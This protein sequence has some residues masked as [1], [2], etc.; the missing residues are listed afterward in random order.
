MLVITAPG[1]DGAAGANTITSPGTGK[2]VLTVGASGNGQS[3]VSNH[4]AQGTAANAVAG[5]SSR[6]PAPFNR[7]KPDIV[8][9]G[10]QIA[11]IKAQG[12]AANANKDHNAHNAYSYG[13]GTSYAAPYV[14]GMAALVRQFLSNNAFHNNNNAIG[15]R[16][17]PSGMLV[18][19]FIINGAHRINPAG[20][21][22]PNNNEGYG[23][24]NLDQ[25]I[26]PARLKL[27]YD[28]GDA[29]DQHN[30]GNA[31]S[32]KRQNDTEKTFNLNLTNQPLSITLVWYDIIDGGV[33]GALVCDLDLT[34]EAANGDIYR[35]DVM[36]L[37]TVKAVCSI[38]D[39]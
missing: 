31:F 13:K 29:Q 11:A 17:T 28:S 39:V 35:G 21:H 16:A 18:K 1:N 15:Q 5:L 34:L 38:P 2:N 9:P 36:V 37:I 30:N 14:S 8:A 12:I 19:A 27:V 26:D 23:L 10:Y 32:L 20:A 7:L 24:V 3:V 25:S 22:I 6:G 4:F 33:T